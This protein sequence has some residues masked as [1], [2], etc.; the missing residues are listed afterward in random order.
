M[1][2]D[3][4]GGREDPAAAAASHLPLARFLPYRLSVLSNRISARIADLY[5]RRFDLTLPEWRVMAVL[6]EAAAD[7]RP[8]SAQEVAQRTAMDKVM[9]SRAVARLIAAGRVDR[10]VAADD[11]RRSVLT[12]TAEGRHIHDAV[13]PLAQAYERALL[14]RL[15]PRDRAAL[16]RVLSSLE[17]V[18]LAPLGR[19]VAAFPPPGDGDS[20]T[21]AG[22]GNG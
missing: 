17:G 15:S 4:D 9:V 2:R 13:V 5:E 18:D 8:M 10:A 12:L 7:D 21:D 20:D 6:G 19:D 22:P 14:D 3:D 1:A 16:D 11:R